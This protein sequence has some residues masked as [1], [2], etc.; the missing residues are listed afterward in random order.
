MPAA[1]GGDPLLRAAL[2][3]FFNKYFKPI[4][5]VTPEHIVL[6]AGATDAIENVIYSI[7]DDGD[8]VL[9]PGPAWRKSSEGYPKTKTNFTSEKVAFLP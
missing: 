3:S 9:V 5:T 2:A 1:D 7:C 6:T 8:S 4:H